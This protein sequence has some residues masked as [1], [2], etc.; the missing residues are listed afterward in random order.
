MLEHVSHHPE[1]AN[2]ILNEINNDPHSDWYHPKGKVERGQ[3]IEESVSINGKQQGDFDY[4]R[5]RF[6]NRNL[7]YF[8]FK[9]MLSLGLK[10]NYDFNPKLSKTLDFCNFVRTITGET[11][12][13]GRMCVWKLEPRSYLLPHVDNWEYHRHITRYIFC[14]SD[15]SGV[16]VTVKIKNEEVPIQQGLLFSFFPATE[17]HEFVNHTDRNFYFLGY[18]YWREKR[19]PFLS[20]VFNVTADTTIP[21]E[22]GYGTQEHQ[23]MSKE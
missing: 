9:N 11:E 2:I 3:G 4:G 23:Y 17:L 21:Y 6:V 8:Y 20:T 18:D 15:H 1:W 5:M 19:L 16:D 22:E 10:N 13:F 7:N 12:P 14:V